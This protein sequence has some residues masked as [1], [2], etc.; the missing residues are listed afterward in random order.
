MTN[1]AWMTLLRLAASLGFALLM[2]ACGTTAPAAPA[3]APA[4]AAA[5]P[6]SASA[7]A[8]APAP[9]SASVSAPEGD[10]QQLVRRGLEA[11]QRID[12]GR[13][14]EVW[15]EASAAARQQV[16]RADFARQIAQARAPLGEVQARQW[17]GVQRRVQGANSAQP[18]EYVILE[19]ETRFAGQGGAPVREQVVFRREADGQLRVAGYFM[20]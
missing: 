16:A 1:T 6:A 8:P 13:A 15:D 20:R 4:A 5:A 3:A 7:P 2:A 10:T 9:A 17:V 11:L 14:G 19:Y 12:Q 18:G